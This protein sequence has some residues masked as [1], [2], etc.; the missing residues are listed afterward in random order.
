MAQILNFAFSNQCYKKYLHILVYIYI[1]IS[2]YIIYILYIYILFVGEIL[3]TAV[4]SLNQHV[5]TRWWDN[6]H[7]ATAASCRPPGPQWP[8]PAVP[9]TRLRMPWAWW[10][11]RRKRWQGLGMD[12][13][14]HFFGSFHRKMR[15]PPENR[16]GGRMSPPLGI[17]GL[18]GRW[19]CRTPLRSSQNQDFEA[20]KSHPGKSRTRLG[21]TRTML[22][23]EIAL[24]TERPFQHQGS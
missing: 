15:L 22:L 24:P 2:L 14:G 4:G 7:L 18:G 3:L 11:P 8:A 1:Y 21:Y 10:R 6:A 12:H 19:R 9:T 17:V 23:S 13:F 5:A 16:I 20:R